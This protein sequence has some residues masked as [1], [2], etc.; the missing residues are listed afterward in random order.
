MKESFKTS[1]D[2]PSNPNKVQILG[3]LKQVL[4]AASQRAK[5]TKLRS[6]KSFWGGRAGAAVQTSQAAA[7][8]IPQASPAGHWGLLQGEITQP[9]KC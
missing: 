4:P 9:C 3:D 5:E 1:R 6:G 2:A 8:G 7:G